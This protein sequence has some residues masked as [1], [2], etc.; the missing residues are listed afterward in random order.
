MSGGPGVTPSRKKSRTPVIIG[1]V[2]AVLGLLVAGVL[3]R[4]DQHVA[5]WFVVGGVLLAGFVYALVAGG[6]R[7]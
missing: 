7:D 3:W 1:A 4:A 5:A 2:I 6:S